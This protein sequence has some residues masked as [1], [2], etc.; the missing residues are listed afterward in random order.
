MVFS[1]GLG[2]NWSRDY[3]IARII[4]AIRNRSFVRCTTLISISSNRRT[5]VG[6]HSMI[7]EIRLIAS[8]GENGVMLG[9]VKLSSRCLWGCSNNHGRNRNVCNAGN[10]SSFIKATRL[11]VTSRSQVS[12]MTQNSFTR[13]VTEDQGHVRRRGEDLLIDGILL[14]Q[15]FI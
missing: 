8:V 9:I 13:V 12:R 7:R 11:T 3:S 14:L 2:H 4:C 1:H 15:V 6:G 5:I 10:V